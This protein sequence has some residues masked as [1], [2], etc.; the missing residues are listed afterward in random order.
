[1]DNNYNNKYEEYLRN[2]N[3]LMFIFEVTKCCGYST[4]VSVYKNLSLINLYSNVIEHFGNNEIKELYFITEDGERINIPISTQRIS[5]YIKQFVSCNPI[6]LVPIYDLPKP[7]IY[8][9]YLIDNSCLCNQHK[10]V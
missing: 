3:N 2:T 7:T 6:K 5:D 9:L 10:C 8:R 1:M 4:F